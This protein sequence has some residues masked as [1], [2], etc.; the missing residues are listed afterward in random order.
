MIVRTWN[1]AAPVGVF[2]S[3]HGRE[4]VSAV[5]GVGHA[6]YDTRIAAGTADRLR[7]GAAHPFQAQAHYCLEGEGTVTIDGRCWPLAPDMIVAAPA[8]ADVMLTADSDLR[9]CT[10]FAG[11]DPLPAD[12]APLVRAVAEIEGSE[13]DV[14]WGNGQSRRLLVRSDGFG[15]ALC[16]TLGNANTDSPLEYR[17]HFESCYY[18]SGSGEYVW[19][20]GRHP[21]D[22]NGAGGT[23][24]IMNHNDAHRMVVADPSMC[25]SV[26]T[27]PIEG[28][29]SHDFSG[30]HPSSY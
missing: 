25:L 30:A 4:I 9:V 1:A 8:S 19:G 15:F 26:F 3:S 14:F 21:I 5:D 2:N 27:P 16:Q 20:D 6:V 28:H 18:V 23:V 10:I 24:F 22:T 13:R 29:E 17:H 11:E 7:E 12:T